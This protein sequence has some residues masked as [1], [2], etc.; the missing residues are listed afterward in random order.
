M[1]ELHFSK[2]TPMGEVKVVLRIIRH[3]LYFRY[4]Q[5]QMAEQAI[6]QFESKGV[7]VRRG[8]GWI[9]VDFVGDRNSIKIGPYTIDL[10]EET[11]EQIETKLQDFYTNQ[12][13]KSGFKLLR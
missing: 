13:I 1:K 4:S 7:K 3:L 11:N 12:F 2:D 9:E 10:E 6:S 5:S 8:D